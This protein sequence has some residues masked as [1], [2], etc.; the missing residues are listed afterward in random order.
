MSR[1]LITGILFS[2]LCVYGCSA[3]RTATPDAEKPHFSA[4]MEGAE[5]PLTFQLHSE[6]EATMRVV[7]LLEAQPRDISVLAYIGK[8]QLGDAATVDLQTNRFIAVNLDLTAPT[9]FGVRSDDPATPNKF[10]YLDRTEIHDYLMM[11][12]AYPTLCGNSIAQ[13]SGLMT[14]NDGTMV[15]VV[16][17]F[18]D[19]TLLDLTLGMD[20]RAYAIVDSTE[21]HLIYDGWAYFH[22]NAGDSC[23]GEVSCNK[24]VKT[25]TCVGGSVGGSGSGSGSSVEGQIEVKWSQST[26]RIDVWAD[27]SCYYADTDLFI[28][29]D[30]C[31][32]Q[33]DA[34]TAC[35]P[36]SGSPGSCSTTGASCS[37]GG[38]SQCATQ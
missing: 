26:E 35:Y 5:V 15:D 34:T 38:A 16:L 7:G 23:E 25:E 32:C 24:W 31:G 21:C 33:I 2:S 36:G 37:G 19:P 18:Q 28:L 10:E 14:L 29:N 1:N 8:N 6:D 17:R 13:T 9:A 4:L 3:E 27:G 12:D 22:C 30:V 11:R 20:E